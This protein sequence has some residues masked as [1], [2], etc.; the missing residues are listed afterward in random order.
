MNE[1]RNSMTPP[2][3]DSRSLTMLTVLII[4]NFGVV[5]FIACR[6]MGC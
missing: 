6:A 5:A 4:F 1:R 3:I 2:E